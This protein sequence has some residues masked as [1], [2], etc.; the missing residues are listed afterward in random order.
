MMW[1][2]EINLHLSSYLSVIDYTSF[3]TY[4]YVSTN[5]QDN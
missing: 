1:K 4:E 2:I 3:K 5:K